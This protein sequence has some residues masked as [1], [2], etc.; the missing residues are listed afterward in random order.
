MPARVAPLVPEDV[1]PHWEMLAGT[2]GERRAG[3][4][5]EHRA[6]AYIR[7]EYRKAGCDDARMEA[8]PCNSRVKADAHVEA[9]VDGTWEK[10]AT[11]VL[12]GSPGTKP[13]GKLLDLELVWHEMPQDAVYLKPNALKGKA[14]FLFGPLATDTKNHKRIVQSGAEVVLWVDD[15]VAFDW[16]KSDAILPVWAKR[17]GKRPTIAVGYQPAYRW[18]VKGVNRVRVRL[19]T[20]HAEKDSYNVVGELLGSDPKAGIVTLGCHYDT[21]C[22]NPGADDNGSGTV[23]L[24]AL[25]KKFAAAAKA[26]P[27]RRTLRFV[28]FGTEEQLSVGARA[29]VLQHK[30]EMK[31]H[32]MMFNYD[33]C[34]SALGHNEML[35]AGSAQLEA[36]AV[37]GM[38]KGGAPVRVSHL[39]TPF[40]DH[41]P[42]NVFGVPALWFYRPNTNGIRWQ[43]HGPH[44]TLETVCPRALCR[45][46]N[47][48]IPLVAAAADARA[49]PFKPGMKA[50]DKPAIKRFAKELFD[51]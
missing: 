24:L 45:L 29:Y 21:Q 16:P 46:V 25:A 42:F 43:H 30:A 49:L 37:K 9:L 50:E 19:S 7:D 38:A 35:V 44:D 51:I 40:A 22:G 27:F 28:A 14:L 10:A 23:T 2:I 12:V 11:E 39:V 6:A 8:F 15:R 33:S 48:T 34:S 17:H 1:W 20:E 31:H 26:K 47:A 41:F 32:A 5:A 18:R 4:E 3:S 13:D 36:W